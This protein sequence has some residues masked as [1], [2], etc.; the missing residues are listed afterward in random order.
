MRR[1]GESMPIH[2]G[3]ASPTLQKAIAENPDIAAR[4]RSLSVQP[5]GTESKQI[6]PTARETSELVTT[7][8]LP[9]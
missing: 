4:L 5:T 6:E 9:F 7:R 3:G 2:Y 1:A 8:R